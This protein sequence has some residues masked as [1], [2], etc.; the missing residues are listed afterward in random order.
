MNLPLDGFGVPVLS[1]LLLFLAVTVLLW[2]LLPFS[3]FGIKSKLDE[4]L[5]VLRSLD[6]RLERLERSQMGQ[7]RQTLRPEESVDDPIRPGSGS[8][9]AGE[10][11][12]QPVVGDVAA[13]SVVSPAP[14]GDS[15]WQQPQRRGG[16]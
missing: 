9:S 10:E 6:A 2:L 7:V 16:G 15:R 4:Q 3:I 8:S 13:S 5:R 11:P 14:G 1:L 12:H